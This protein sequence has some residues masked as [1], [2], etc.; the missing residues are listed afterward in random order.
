MLGDGWAGGWGGEL[1]LY[2]CYNSLIRDY[3]D[4]LNIGGKS[5]VALTTN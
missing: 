4:N 5:E 2:L 1:L 3:E